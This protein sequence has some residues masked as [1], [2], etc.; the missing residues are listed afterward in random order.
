MEGIVTPKLPYSFMTPPPPVPENEIKE[1]YYTQVVVV[2][3]GLGGVSAAARARELGLDV[4]LIEKSD[5]YSGRGGH[6]GVAWSS[7]MEEKGIVLDRKELVRQ[8]I[9]R[10]GNRVKEELIWL[11]VNRSGE[12]MNWFIPKAIAAGLEP[13]L[14]DCRYATSPYTEYYG[15]HAFPPGRRIRGNMVT[16]VLYEEAVANGV[17]SMFEIAGHQLIKEGDR[18]TGVIAKTKNEYIR[19]MAS[20][21]VVLATGDIGGDPEMLLAYAPDALKTC[22]SQYTPVGM[23]TGDGHKMGLWVGAAMAEEKFPICMHPQHYTWQSFFFLFVNQ[24]GKRFMNE[25]TYVQGKA[26][27]LLNQPCGA[28]AYSIFDSKWPEQVK[29]SLKYGGGIFWGSAALRVGQEWTM[30]LPLESIND[31]IK[32]GCAWKADTLEELADKMGVPKDTFLATVARYNE[33][34]RNKN[35]IDFGKRS[36]LLY[37]IENPPFYSLKF[38]AVLLFVAGGLEIDTKIR[39]LDKDKKPIPGLYAV[40]D[41]TGGMYGHEYV[42]TILGNSHGRAMTWGYLAAETISELARKRK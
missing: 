18:V 34:A 3:A 4:I 22:A 25:D 21:G 38:G 7:L 40:G 5:S 11:F 2:G 14:I 36:E 13:T 26:T 9:A 1:T 32:K 42:T 6:Y 10:S 8:W 17:K 29:D 28:W 12:A 23:N 31:G 24:L 35:D 41:T 39:V 33:L 15:A 16:R 30:D 27:A 37:P 19:I 20:E